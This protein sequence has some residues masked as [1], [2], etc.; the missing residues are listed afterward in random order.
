MKKSWFMK[1]LDLSFLCLPLL[2]FLPLFSMTPSPIVKKASCVGI[3]LSGNPRHP[4]ICGGGCTD[5]GYQCKNR[6][7][8]KH[9][10]ELP[11]YYCSCQSGTHHT[12]EPVCCHLIARKKGG[13]FVLEVKGICTKA[14]GCAYSDGRICQLRDHQPVC[15]PAVPPQMPQ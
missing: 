13:E 6:L 1:G 9:G 2:A 14:E 15:L 4:L 7:V 10:K 12:Q 8:Q 5:V 3:G 11:Y